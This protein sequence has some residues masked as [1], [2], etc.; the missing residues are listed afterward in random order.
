MGFNRTKEPK[1][2]W[3]L[4][5]MMMTIGII[6]LITI[7]I[8]YGVA[9]ALDPTLTDNIS[10]T[11]VIIMGVVLCSISGGILISSHN[12]FTVTYEKYETN[13]KIHD[14]HE[15]TY[16]HLMTNGWMTNINLQGENNE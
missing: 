7:S 3:L 4:F 1:P 9:T 6:G 13:E 16:K 8:G 15:N 10:G 2:D 12:E 11:I 5:C 14:T